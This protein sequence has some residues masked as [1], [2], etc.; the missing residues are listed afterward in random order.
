MAG[1]T[2]PHNWKA[3]NLQ[4]G[5]ADTGP[6]QPEGPLRAGYTE[7]GSQPQRPHT[8]TPLTSKLLHSGKPK[9]RAQYSSQG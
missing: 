1:H 9:D 3:L 8:V 4:G 6:M 2:P 5:S 7:E